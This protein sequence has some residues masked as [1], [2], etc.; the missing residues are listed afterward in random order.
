MGLRHLGVALLLASCAACTGCTA[1]PVGFWESDNKLGNG[2]RNKLEVYDDYTGN[3]KLYATLS[4]DPETW[5]RFEFDIIWEDFGDVF[6]FD[7]NCSD[8]PCESNADDFD[9][10]MT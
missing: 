2:K 8:G 10:V 9:M 5:Y 3:A 6:E 1:P 7:L 4:N